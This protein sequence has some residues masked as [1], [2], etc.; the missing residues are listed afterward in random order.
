MLSS[1][2]NRTTEKLMEITMLEFKFNVS[3]IISTWNSEEY[4]LK[5]TD[6]DNR[7]HTVYKKE[8]LKIKTLFYYFYVKTMV[9][10]FSICQFYTVRNYN[11]NGTRPSGGNKKK[12][13]NICMYIFR[14]LIQ[15]CI[16]NYHLGLDDISKSFWII[17]YS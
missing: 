2:R 7:S 15:I 6:F 10:F 11:S 17:Q 4:T 3:N 5:V 13:F 9:V 12:N 16:Y 14:F 1:W 8:L